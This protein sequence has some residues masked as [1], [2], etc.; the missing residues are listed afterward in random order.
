ARDARRGMDASRRK[1]RRAYGTFGIHSCRNAISAT[2]LSGSTMVAIHP[3]ISEV[4]HW[5][6]EV[7]DP[8][9]PVLSITDLGIVREVRW[10][11]EDKGE[12][13]VTITPTYSGCPAMDV[14]ADEIRAALQNHGI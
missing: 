7:A 10:S 8:E 6:E 2:R 14:I 5:L 3:P 1:T 9:I 13:V 11:G 4:W 12:L